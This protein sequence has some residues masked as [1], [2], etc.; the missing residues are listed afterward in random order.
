MG[1]SFAVAPLGGTLVLLHKVGLFVRSLTGTAFG[2]LSL[3]DLL[4]GFLLNS[5]L[6]LLGEIVVDLSRDDPQELVLSGVE[7]ALLVVLDRSQG[8]EVDPGH[9]DNGTNRTA[10]RAESTHEEQSHEDEGN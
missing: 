10:D 5:L 6:S 2:L 8:A 7:L 9:K 3:L 1:R 4:L